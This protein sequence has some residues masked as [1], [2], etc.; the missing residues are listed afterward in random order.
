[1][2]LQQILLIVLI[3]F[4]SACVKNKSGQPASNPSISNLKSFEVNEVIQ[5]SQY[6][7]LRVSENSA[8]RWVAVSKM[9]ATV[10]NTYYYDSELQMTNFHSKELDRDFETI[11]FINTVSTNPIAGHSTPPADNTIAGHSG[12]TETKQDGAV[13]FE[14][15]GNEITIAQ[16]FENPENYSNKEIEIRGIVVK[17]N[18]QIMGK[19]WIHIQDGSSFNN[20]FDLTI[21]SQDLPSVND[22]VTFK[23]TIFLNKDFGAGYAYDVIM[24]NAVIV[25]KKT[26]AL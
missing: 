17:V 20:N 15:A 4:S 10:G 2:K 13:S 25:D 12:K 22:E 24:E 21:T 26:T 19:N 3:L 9:D 14:K 8:E 16:I 1:M 18:K 23:G 7:Y 6:T 11:Y 5:T